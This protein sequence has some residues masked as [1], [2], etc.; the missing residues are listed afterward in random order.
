MKNRGS[1]S[2]SVRID[3]RLLT[4]LPYYKKFF[5]RENPH[6]ARQV[7]KRMVREAW[8]RAREEAGQAKRTQGAD[9]VV[10]LEPTE[11]YLNYLADPE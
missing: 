8:L 1:A 11:E 9:G 7:S 10:R 6:L 2:T 5:I 4:F 3:E